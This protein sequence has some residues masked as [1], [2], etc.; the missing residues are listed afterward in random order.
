MFSGDGDGDRALVQA[1]CA[2]FELSDRLV[3]TFD[4]DKQGACGFHTGAALAHFSGLNASVTQQMCS[5]MPALQTVSRY[6]KK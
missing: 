6:L 1:V 3:G 5:L 4:Y 2:R